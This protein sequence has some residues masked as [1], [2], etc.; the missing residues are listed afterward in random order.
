MEAV[1]S[2]NVFRPSL[3]A[4]VFAQQIPYSWVQRD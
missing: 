4:D 1:L 3:P 2:D